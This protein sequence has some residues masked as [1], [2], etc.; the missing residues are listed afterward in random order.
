VRGTDFFY[1]LKII[2]QFTH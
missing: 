2:E 1:F